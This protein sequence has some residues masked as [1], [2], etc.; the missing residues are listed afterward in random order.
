MR[1]AVVT[2]TWMFLAMNIASGQQSIRFADYFIDRTLRVDYYRTGDSTE[3]TIAL[4]QLYEQGTWAGNP[5]SLLDPSGNGRYRAT[6]YDVASNRLI[7]SRGY[8]TYFGEYKTTVPARNGVKRTFHETV[9]V[10]FPVKPILF[11]IER[12]DRQNL[13]HPQFSRRI[14]PDDYH[15]ISE[16]PARGDDIIAVV[17]NGDPHRC[18]DLVIIAEGYVISEKDKFKSDLRRYADLLVAWEPYRSFKDRF[19]IRGIFSPSPQSGVD[20]PRQHGYRHTLL[21]AT[22]NSLDSDRYLLTENNRLLRDIAAQVPYDAILIMVNSKRYGG[23]AIYNSFTAFTSDGPQSE[24][25]FQH[26]FAH[27][28]AALA[29]EYYTTDVAYDQFFPPGI[30]PT[31]ANI[32]SLLDPGALK[33]KEFVSAGLPIPTPWGQERYDSLTAA[34]DSLNRARG[35]ELELLTSRHATEEEVAKAKLRFNELTGDVNDR[36]RRFIQNHPL[37][38]KIGAFE[39]GGYVPKGIYRPTVNSL[40]NQFSEDEK[41]FYAVNEQAIIRMIRYYTE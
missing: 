14:A 26:E 12:R 21:G 38:G 7:Y 13:Y 5:G 41:T 8:D 39:G 20:E 17:N 40:M 10:P 28:F 27:A 36:L 32:T 15:I 29:D 16:T 18:T 37:R 31:E 11:V 33:W 4:D 9:L 6:V 24:Y 34:R 35:R 19:N 2:C 3:E 23:G 25:V 22:F 1:N 30:E